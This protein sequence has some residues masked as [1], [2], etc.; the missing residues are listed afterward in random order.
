MNI[1]VELART[2]IAR[3]ER[4]CVIIIPGPNGTLSFFVPSQGE[5]GRPKA[6][7]PY[8]QGTQ[9]GS[10]R[11]I[12]LLIRSSL[13]LKQAVI[14]EIS[15]RGCLAEGGSPDPRPSFVDEPST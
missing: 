9:D 13:Q 12:Q 1:Y 7:G 11:E 6:E 4:Y 8:I 2:L 10:I 14:D 15:S 3:L 5:L